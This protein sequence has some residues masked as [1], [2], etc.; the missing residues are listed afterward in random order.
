MGCKCQ[1]KTVNLLY[2]K[3]KSEVEIILNKSNKTSYYLYRE[4]SDWWYVEKISCV[5]KNAKNVEFIYRP[6]KIKS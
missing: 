2:E 4:K 3:A 1:E 5:P 6:N